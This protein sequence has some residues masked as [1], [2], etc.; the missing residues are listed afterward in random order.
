MEH[1]GE[2]TGEAR[3]DQV[4]AGFGRLDGLSLDEHVA[5]FEDAHARLRQVLSELDSGPADAAGR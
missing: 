2:E 3:V 5:V 4:V 1:D